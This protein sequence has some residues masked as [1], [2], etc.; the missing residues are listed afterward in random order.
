V[1]VL[2][3]AQRYEIQELLGQG[4]WTGSILPWTRKPDNVLLAKDGTP[5]L[6]DF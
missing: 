2:R 1:P 6:S 3:M 5:R 4:E